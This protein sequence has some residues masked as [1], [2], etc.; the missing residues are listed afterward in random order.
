MPANRGLLGARRNGGPGFDFDGII[1]NQ[2]FKLARMFASREQAISLM[3]KAAVG[4]EELTDF[5]ENPVAD[6]LKLVRQKTR[7]LVMEAVSKARAFLCRHDAHHLFTNML[8][9]ALSCKQTAL[10]DLHAGSKLLQLGSLRWHTKPGL[11]R[12]FM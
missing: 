1:G 4:M 3:E 5:L 12:S 2:F 10:Q 11:M 8:Y 9:P 6:P 7:Q